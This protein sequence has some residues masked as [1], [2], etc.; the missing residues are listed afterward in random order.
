LIYNPEPKFFRYI[1]KSHHFVFVF[2]ILF[3]HHTDRIS[4]EVYQG[5]SLRDIGLVLENIEYMKLLFR[6]YEVAGR[7]GEKT[8]VNLIWL[9]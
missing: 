1:E 7:L 4:Q 8:E 9:Q 5:N 2:S 3:V 6:C